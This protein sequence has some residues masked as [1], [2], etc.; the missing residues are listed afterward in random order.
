MKGS[1]LCHRS[2]KNMLVGNGV[3]RAWGARGT[4]AQRG[5]WVLLAP[6]LDTLSPAGRPGRRR[7][8]M[9][10]CTEVDPRPAAL[11]VPAA[12]RGPGPPASIRSHQGPRGSRNGP[13]A[14]WEL[15]AQGLVQQ[16]PPHLRGRLASTPSPPGSRCARL[17]RAPPGS[18]AVPDPLTFPEL[19]PGRGSRPPAHCGAETPSVVESAPRVTGGIRGRPRRGAS[20]SNRVFMCSVCPFGVRPPRGDLGQVD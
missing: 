18:H 12:P 8:P 17:P 16:V 1:G 13:G 20:H 10:P 14:T 3:S 5:P 15:Q 6:G 19:S 11:G 9:S 4:Q 2:T 7:S